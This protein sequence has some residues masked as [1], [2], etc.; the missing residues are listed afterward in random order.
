MGKDLKLHSCR[1]LQ[2]FAFLIMALLF[3]APPSLA[4]L[5][6][7]DP[8]NGR[9]SSQDQTIH[10]GQTFDVDVNLSD[11]T[12]ILTLYLT[13]KFNHNVFKL[14]NVQ[15]VRDALSELN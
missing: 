14:I 12:G 13:V 1:L 5:I 11:N 3:C 8:I 7:A 15:Q 4:G 9:V 10:R 2:L 6:H